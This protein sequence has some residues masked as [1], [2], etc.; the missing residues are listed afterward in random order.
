MDL[1]SAHSQPFLSFL[2]FICAERDLE[3]P[4]DAEGRERV[5]QSMRTLNSIQVLG[6][7]VKLMRWFSWFESEKFYRGENYCNKLLMM[8][9]DN[10]DPTK[11]V[12]FVKNEVLGSI[13][14]KGDKVSEKAELQHLKIQLGTWSLAPLLVTPTSMWQKDFIAIV[15]AASRLHHSKRAKYV[16]TP[17]QVC[18]HTIA[19]SQGA[20]KNELLDMMRDSFYNT[21]NLKKLYPVDSAPDGVRNARLN[22]HL[23]FCSRLLGKRASSICAF[24]LA[25]PVR[26]AALLDPGQ[27]EEMART[28]QSE[29]ERLLELE[30]ASQAGQH[31]EGLYSLQFLDSHYVRLCY[32][33][34]EQDLL[35]GSRE[36]LKILHHALVHF[37]DT[38]CIE[39]THSS[40]KDALR[41]SRSNFRSRVN[42]YFHCISSRVLQS[43]EANHVTISEAELAL[44]KA[45]KLPSVVEATHP[46]SHSLQRKYQDL[47]RHKAGD[48]YWHATTAASQFE[49]VVVLEWLLHSHKLPKHQS[50]LLSCLAGPAGSVIAAADSEPLLV[51]APSSFGFVGWKLEVAAEAG[52]MGEHPAFRP[53]NLASAICFSYISDLEGWVDVPVQPVTVGHHGGLVL[54]QVSDPQPLCIARVKAGLTLTVKQAKACLEWLQHPVKGQPPKAEIFKLLISLLLDSPEERDAAFAK[55]N[56]GG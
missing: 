52:V 38:A 50:P 6:P 32:L 55:S 46:N 53:I 8:D 37:G 9:G 3:E 21:M 48:H 28:M 20:W 15:G 31:V 36:A 19:M 27:H 39:S 42:K 14:D 26:Y 5:F 44:A 56:A 2:P 7:L 23:G 41:D 29:F 35:S 16:L 51:L 10:P 25:P 40:A 11:G 49:Q 22:T 12:D 13:E 17:V 33:A 47:M 45:S 43:R 18:Q 54:L 4:H 1:S 24:T 34:N 30:A